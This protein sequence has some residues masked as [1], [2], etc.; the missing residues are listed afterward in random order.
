MTEKKKKGDA[1]DKQE[2][3]LIAQNKRARHEYFIEAAYEAGIALLG[4][5]V[6]SLRAGRA[7]ITEAYVVL[8]NREAFLIGAH[9][10][11]LKQAST[12][13]VPDPVRTRKLLL[14]ERELS[15]LIGKVERAGYTLVPLDMHWT[16]G[17]AKVQIGL[18]KGK[19]QH[20]K[21]ADMKERD[22]AREKGRIL[23]ARG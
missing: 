19:K 10:T 9:F 21:R 6:K 20:D 17:L 23:R 5:E 2:P 4:W 12:H 15:Q 13:V 3:R 22:W 7:Q 16:R 1:G 14:H 18:A 11:A 8:R